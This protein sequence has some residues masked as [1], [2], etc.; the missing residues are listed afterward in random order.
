MTLAYAGI[1]IIDLTRTLAGPY[2]TMIL[3]DLGA[4]VVKIEAEGGDDARRLPPHWQG[5]SAAFLA[6]NRNKQSVV[7]DLK[8][9]T[10][11]EAVRRLAAG[12]D[13]VVDS[14]RPGV[15]DRLGIG[16]DD[17]TRVNGR[18][19]HC[20]IT[21]FGTGP[22]G[23]DLPGYDPLLQAFSGIMKATGHPGQ[24][25]VRVGPSLVDL[26]TG[27]WA[28]MQMM[29]ALA[30]REAVGGPQRLEVA[31]LDSAINL[32]CHQA[33]GVLAT[34]AAP[35]PQGS[36]SPLAAPYEV[37]AAA[38]GELL[39]A[40]GNDALFGALCRELGRP[41]LARHPDYRDMTGRV[42]HREALHAAIEAALKT[43]GVDAWLVR[44]RAAGVPAGPVQDLAQALGHPLVAERGLLVA[45]PAP[46]NPDLRL[47]R[48]PLS[49]ARAAFAAPPELGRD[50]RAVLRELGLED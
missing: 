17:L 30:R 37:F 28:A 34:G 8:S 44:L 11:R 20:A 38:D 12:A 29:A 18:L 35:E 21:G 50:T 6:A 15:A 22:L 25:P 47:L 24:P 23:R 9:D 3:S 5:A 33:L 26:T 32:M 48:L 1:R 49:D 43:A 40:A 39:I 31:L 10:W 45:S 16:F 46:G 2:A 7:L 27:M 42:A 4:E 36:G 13:I 19:I 41:D 14:F